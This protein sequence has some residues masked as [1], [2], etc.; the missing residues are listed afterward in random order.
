M[1]KKSGLFEATAWYGIGNLVVR[2][3]SFI[4]LPLYSNLIPVEQ[5]G[6]Y[7]LMMSVYAISGVFYHFGMN[8]SLTNFYLKENDETARKII[9]S[10]IVNAIIIL[11]LFLTIIAL[12]ISSFLTDKILG[13]SEYSILVI[14]L[15][16]IIFVETV[17]NYIL[18]L[19]KTLELSKKVVIYLFAGAV[20][21]L[22]LN[23]WF[24]Y[25]LRIGIK[26]IIFA[27]LLT[28]IIVFI[29]LLPL[30]KGSYTFRIDKKILTT[31]VIFSLPL[32]ISGLFSSGM[33]VA[34]RFVLDRFLGKKEVGEYSFAYR[35]AMIT[36]IFVISFRAAWMP[37]ALNK[38]KEGNYRENFGK[39][40]IKVIAIGVF[41]LLTVSFFADDLFVIKIFSKNLFNPIYKAGL[42]ILPYVVIGYIFN[43][44]ASFYSLYPFTAN[45]S[46]HFLI[47]DGL[48][49]ISNLI[50]N[51]IL[52]P[53]YGMLGA[54][55][56]TSISFIM[57]AGYLYFIS[58]NKI[59]IIYPRKEITITCLVGIG[60]LLLG[61]I[62]NY[63]WVQILCVILF[64]S[65]L[66]FIVKLKPASLFRLLQ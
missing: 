42:V 32:F 64:L 31:A 35:L 10:T 30:V 37:Y 1:Q 44:L 43:S 12:S 21:N 65:I 5:F 22:L 47:S 2:L 9:F 14:L 60:V 66:I 57:A 6:I 56:A 3:V 34:D 33:D 28:A 40:F 63:F 50:L 58:K 46:Y 20:I 17:S 25:G 38:F 27:H 29:L 54:G 19:F 23:I 26:G 15:F 61:M 11:G 24:V 16:I 8:A 49:V 13:S 59:E 51:F 18:Q 52:I 39:I 55:I 48:G 53:V 7:S 4:L 41:I 45:K 62:L 36:N